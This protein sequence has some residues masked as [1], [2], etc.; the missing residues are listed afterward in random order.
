MTSLSDYENELDKLDTQLFATETGIQCNLGGG[1]FFPYASLTNFETA[2]SVARDL[3]L[4]FLEENANASYLAKRFLRLASNRPK[5]V[6]VS[7]VLSDFFHRSV[8]GRNSI[9]KTIDIDQ[10]FRKHDFHQLTVEGNQSISI[11]RN[12]GELKICFVGHQPHFFFSI[13]KAIGAKKTGEQT[14]IRI[15]RPAFADWHFIQFL[16]T[17][18]L[19]IVLLSEYIVFDLPLSHSWLDTSDGKLTNWAQHDSMRVAVKHDFSDSDL[20]SVISNLKEIFAELNLQVNP[21]NA[22]REKYNFAKLSQ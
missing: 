1:Y 16:D 17:Q 4:F 14:P 6:G 11:S 12:P 19:E 22:I 7:A 5:P 15:E 2:M 3:S 9:E 13:S 20:Q 8:L 21:L 10:E 18:F